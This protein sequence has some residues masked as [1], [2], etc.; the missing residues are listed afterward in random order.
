MTPVPF[1]IG[2]YLESGRHPDG[3]NVARQDD[4]GILVTPTPKIGTL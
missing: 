4:K 1:Y 2:N 3:I